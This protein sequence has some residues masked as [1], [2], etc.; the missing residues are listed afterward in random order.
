M[1]QSNIFRSM[2]GCLKLLDQNDLTS[3]RAADAKGD[4]LGTRL[5][6]ASE[7]G[8]AERPGTAGMAGS[9]RR[10]RLA[11]LCLQLLLQLAESPVILRK[12]V[13]K[14]TA[15]AWLLVLVVRWKALCTRA[16]PALPVPDRCETVATL[17]VSCSMLQRLVDV[18]GSWPWY[19]RRIVSAM[20]SGHNNEASQCPGVVCRLCPSNRRQQAV[21]RRDL[22]GKFR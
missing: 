20:A 12:M 2:H 21:C 17:F 1:H 8:Y 4:L 22:P 19:A 13:K 6:A 15:T 18:A 16:S 7:S 11:R 9:S 3:C 5:R 14:V 10:M